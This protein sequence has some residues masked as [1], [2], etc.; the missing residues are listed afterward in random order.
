MSKKQVMKKALAGTFA[1]A[2]LMPSFASAEQ[3]SGIASKV[4][5]AAGQ[6]VIEALT[7]DILLIDGKTI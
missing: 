3:S 4:H 1:F 5:G 7:K 6:P 2:L